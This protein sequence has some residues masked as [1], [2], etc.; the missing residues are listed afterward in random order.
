MSVTFSNIEEKNTFHKEVREC[1]EFVEYGKTKMF[2]NPNTGKFYDGSVVE[3]HIRQREPLIAL[4]FPL[5]EEVKRTHAMPDN[6][7]EILEKFSGVK[8]VVKEVKKEAPIEISIPVEKD[9]VFIKP[10]KKVVKH[11]PLLKKKSK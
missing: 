5:T 8:K 10:N 4:E 6:Y 9:E 1:L 7:N 2:Y 11:P 3:R